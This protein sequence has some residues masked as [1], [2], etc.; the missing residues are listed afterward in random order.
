[1]RDR[2]GESVRSERPPYLPFASKQRVN[3]TT[4]QPLVTVSNVELE[5]DLLELGADRHY[6]K[7]A[8]YPYSR[9][10]YMSRVCGCG[11]HPRDFQDID[12]LLHHVFALDCIAAGSVSLSGDSGNCQRSV[13]LSI[14]SRVGFCAT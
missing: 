12:A 11:K 1:M 4:S 13:E 9:M 14:T 2:D 7:V 8:A 5:G 3:T 6:S 10:S